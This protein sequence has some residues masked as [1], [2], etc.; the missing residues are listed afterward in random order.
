AAR[1]KLAV[2]DAFHGAGQP[3]LAGY[4]VTTSGSTLFGNIAKMFIDEPGWQV[5]TSNLPG[6]QNAENVPTIGEQKQAQDYEKL[7]RLADCEPTLT[8]FH[9]FPMLD[10]FDRSTLLQSGV[11]R[12][13]FSERPSAIDQTNSV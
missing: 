5:D 7:V 12:L 3:V 10:E 4:P 11:L 8:D 1:V 2:W 6:Y 13:D 9:I